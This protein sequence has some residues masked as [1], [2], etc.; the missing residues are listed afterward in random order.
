MEIKKGRVRERPDRKSMNAKWTTNVEDEISENKEEETWREL[1][2]REK[3]SEEVVAVEEEV[4]VV[5]AVV[6][7][8]VIHFKFGAVLM[9]NRSRS[10][11]KS[12]SVCFNPWPC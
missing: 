11:I 5:E 2:K 4:V 8:T 10:Q 7:Q 12:S 6:T 9:W 3:E 1:K